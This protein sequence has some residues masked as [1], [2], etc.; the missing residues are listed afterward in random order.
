MKL[1]EQLLAELGAEALNALTF[2]PLKACYFKDVRTVL[3][4]SDTS[5]TLVS[6]KNKVILKGEGLTVKSYF[7]GDLFIEGKV[8][9]VEIE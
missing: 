1:L 8:R 6:G 9:S 7:C 3:D 4:L 5:V 2:I